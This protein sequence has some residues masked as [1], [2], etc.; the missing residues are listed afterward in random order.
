MI[1]WT[2]SEFKQTKTFSSKKDPGVEDK[3]TSYRLRKKTKG[4]TFQATFPTKDWY[5]VYV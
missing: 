1:N 4:K 3:Q 5:L 2:S